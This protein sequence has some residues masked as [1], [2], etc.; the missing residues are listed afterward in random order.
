MLIVG[1]NVMNDTNKVSYIYIC[2]VKKFAVIIL[3][4]YDNTSFDNIMNN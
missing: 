3:C 2:N 1:Y 4:K